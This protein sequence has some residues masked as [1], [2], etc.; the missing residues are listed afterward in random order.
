VHFATTV[1]FKI[2]RLLIPMKSILWIKNFGP[3]Y[4]AWPKKWWS[5]M[6]WSLGKNFFFCYFQYFWKVCNK[7]QG[8]YCW[9][10]KKSPKSTNPT[11]YYIHVQYVPS[12]DGSWYSVEQSANRCK[13]SILTFYIIFLTK[14]NAHL[15]FPDV[16]KNNVTIFFIIP[17][18]YLERF[19]KFLIDNFYF[20]TGCLL[21]M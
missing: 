5:M 9:K 19:L 17:L 11:V 15:H 3:L 2:L 20:M 8:Y 18:I 4:S 10:C 14:I 21:I 1:S 7:S 6:K 12:R 16:W 13:N